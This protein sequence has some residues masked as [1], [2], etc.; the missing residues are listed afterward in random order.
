[1]SDSW[2]RCA[3]TNGASVPSFLP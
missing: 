3:V 1:M 2:N